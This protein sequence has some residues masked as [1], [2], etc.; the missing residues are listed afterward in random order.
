M[1]A[2]AY[3]A[4]RNMQAR[5]WWWRGM[6]RLYCAALDRFVPREPTPVCARRLLD[7]GCGFG[8]NL[9]ALNRFGDVAGVDISL[10]VLRAIAQRPA[11]GLVQAR[12][13]ALP[14]R[15][16]TFDVVA[17][18]AV[19]EHADRDDCVL[20]ET[21]RVTRP[22]GIQILLTSAFMF[23]WSRHDLANV[24]RRRYHANELD[25]LQRAAGW[26]VL[27]ASYVNACVF[28]MVAL[29]RLIQRWFNRDS[30]VP[31][32]DMGL[33]LGPLNV[34]LE[35]LL[36]AEAWLIMRRVRLPFGVNL[37]SVSRRGDGRSA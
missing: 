32:Y 33:N 37:F 10:D 26:D 9:S 25:D 14:F 35:T 8:S 29:V 34:L 30:Q 23:L 3:E 20:A 36:G 16:G 15:S 2:H 22:G 28:P 12:A 1:K 6:R 7:V 13:D 18:L 27:I 24:H 21:C 17:A 5:H 19:L 11:L 31:A 4:M